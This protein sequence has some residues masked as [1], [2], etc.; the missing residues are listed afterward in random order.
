MFEKTRA[1]FFPVELVPGVVAK[2]VGSA[3]IDR[4]WTELAG[5]IFSPLASLGNFE[6]PP[7]RLKSAEALK[8]VWRETHHEYIVFYDD[9]R[10][11]GWSSGALLEPATFFMAYSGVLS[12]YRR[13][14][15]Y[16]A[17]LEVFLRYLGALGY[18]RVTSNH[19]LNN[20]AVL[21]AKLKAG[22]VVSGMVLDERYGAQV[23]LTYF[24]HTDRAEGFARA[25]G[26][27]PGR[28]PASAKP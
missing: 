20:R 26:L 2:S 9:T 21:I 17:F 10:P 8:G 11:I 19:M 25:F 24:C 1:T 12:E 22:F 18:E 4:V 16:S 14:G 27:E 23:A 15:V 7:S 13:Q 6:T 28:P 5:K 3:E